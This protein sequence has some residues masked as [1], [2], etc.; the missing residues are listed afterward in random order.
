MVRLGK[1][2]EIQESTKPAFRITFEEGKVFNP[3][4]LYFRVI[5]YDTL[6]EGIWSRR[7]F[8]LKNIMRGKGGPKKGIWGRVYLVGETE[9]YLPILYGIEQIRAESHIISYRDGVIRWGGPPESVIKYE[10]YVQ[11]EPLLEI[12]E[13]ITDEEKELYLQVPKVSDSIRELAKSLAG[14]SKE[15]TLKNIL[16]FFQKQGFRYTLKNLPLGEDALEEFLFKSKK[17]NCEYFASAVALL[18]RLNGVPARLVGGY[19]SAIYQERGNYYLVQQNFAHSWVE[20][21]LDGSWRLI[22]TT[23]PAGLNLTKENNSFISKIK[24]LWDTLNFYY[25]KFIVDYDL[26]KQKRLLSIIKKGIFL[27]KRVDGIRSME[28]DLPKSSKSLP[29]LILMILLIVFLVLMLMLLM[30]KRGILFMSEEKRL[31]MNFLRS[32][33]KRGYR[34]SESEGLL[35]LIAKIKEPELKKRCL[36]FVKI[37]S[38]YYYRERKFDREILLKLKKYLE[39]IKKWKG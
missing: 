18:L 4:N 30:K 5:V 10:I 25:V 35:E 33:E 24:L 28:R 39:D 27:E 7:E 26:T 17:G 6:S 32:L 3:E 13:E 38:E 2:S 20:A 15:E 34:R 31:L 1:F 9:G 23:P 12:E 8:H 29:K 19:R 11:K 14:K 37:Y 36:P 16:Q 21:Y 22:E